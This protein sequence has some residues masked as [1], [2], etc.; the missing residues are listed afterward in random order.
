MSRYQSSA[1]PD[2]PLNLPVVR[3]FALFLAL[4]LSSSYNT[5]RYKVR[6]VIHDAQWHLETVTPQVARLVRVK[7]G[8]MAWT[9]RNI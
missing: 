8:V 2:G 6:L 5:R 3:I 4:S 7:K 1:A 9:E